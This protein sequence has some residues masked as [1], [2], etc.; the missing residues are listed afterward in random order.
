MASSE[1]QRKKSIKPEFYTQKIF[2]KNEYKI[3][4]IAYKTKVR[5]FTANRAY[6]QEMQK[7]SPMA[8]GK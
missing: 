5:E 3:K 6:L 2:L 1:Y 8:E 7:E 4:T